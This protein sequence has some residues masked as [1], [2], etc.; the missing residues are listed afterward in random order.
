MH[1]GLTGC[2]NYFCITRI[3]ALVVLVVVVVLVVL[4]VLVVV[5][6]DVSQIKA[7]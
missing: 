3:V 4:V 5:R 1:S 2:H 6:I 7:F